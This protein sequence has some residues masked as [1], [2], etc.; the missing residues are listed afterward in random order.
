MESD[1]NEEDSKC[2]PQIYN[3]ELYTNR[4]SGKTVSPHIQSDN[5]SISFD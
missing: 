4:I 1:L 5:I 2:N 3:A